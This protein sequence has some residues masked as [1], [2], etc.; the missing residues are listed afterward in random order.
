MLQILNWLCLI[1]VCG[2]SAEIFLYMCKNA[3]NIFE[4]NTKKSKKVC[5]HN[6]DIS[7]DTEKLI[8]KISK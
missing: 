6:V 4:N 5:A 2:L 8:N 1:S 7:I 3:M